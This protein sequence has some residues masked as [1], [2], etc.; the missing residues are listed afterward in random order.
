VMPTWPHPTWP[1][2]QRAPKGCSP[3]QP[4]FF[5]VG[6]LLHCPRLPRAPGAGA[7]SRGHCKPNQPCRLLI[8]R[9]YHRHHHHAGGMAR[10]YGEVDAGADRFAAI[11][12]QMWVR[13]YRSGDNRR[14]A[15]IPRKVTKGPAGLDGGKGATSRRLHSVC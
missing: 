7:F 12:M 1:T 3:R 8:D 13:I 14:T 10:A 4:R 9:L 6:C 11:Y 15:E 2:L 5:S